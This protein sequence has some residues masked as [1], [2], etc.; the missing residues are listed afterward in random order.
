MHLKQKLSVTRI[1]T[2]FDKFISCTGCVS[3]DPEIKN[4]CIKH[5][6]YLP[7]QLQ[8]SIFNFMH[9]VM[10]AERTALY[11]IILS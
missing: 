7:P 3:A 6:S 1:F 2:V 9:P 10:E 4:Q 5:L 8:K 11:G